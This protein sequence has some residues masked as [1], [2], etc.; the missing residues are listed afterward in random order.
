MR[1]PLKTEVAFATPWFQI[2]GKTMREGEE[3]YYSLRLPDYAVAVA[4]TA[5]QRVLIVRQ[6][7]PAVERDTLELPSGI[8][9]TGETPLESARRELLEETGYAGGEWVDLGGMEPDSGRLGNRI[10]S[11]VA[12]GVRRVEGRAPEEGIE[13]L[14]WSLEE[15]AQ[16]MADGR[17]SMALHVAAV[18]MAVVKG[19]LRLPGVATR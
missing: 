2:V 13:V 19:G 10:W 4:I 18:M 1:K 7:R 15:L 3:P 9:D 11:F 12:K 14:T 5:E 17:F 16:A 6:Y 8:V